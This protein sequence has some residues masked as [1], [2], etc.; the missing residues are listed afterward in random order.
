MILFRVCDPRFPFLW[1]SAAQPAARWHREGEGPVHYL[2]DTPVGAWAEFLRHEAIVDPTDLAGVERSLWALEVATRRYATP[3]LDAAVLTGGEETYER[4]RDEAAR[5]RARRVRGLRAPSAALRSGKAH[6][7]RVDGGE[8]PGRD[9]D[10][11]VYVLFG[12]RPAI[13]GWPVVE[14]GAPPARTL[15]LVRPL[16]ARRLS[17]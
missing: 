17:D 8:H 13:V 12:R 7:W 11:R 6:G 15:G 3:R 2:A 4:C 1:E 9:R 16:P 10:G 5:L 14:R